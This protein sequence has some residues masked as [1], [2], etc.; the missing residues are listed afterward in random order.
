MALRLLTGWGQSA[1]IYTEQRI[2]W[3]RRLEESPER[4]ADEAAFDKILPPIVESA[5]KV[6]ESRLR[7]FS[8]PRSMEQR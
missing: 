2:V 7:L 4:T 8:S 1:Y 6:A 3:Q 5:T